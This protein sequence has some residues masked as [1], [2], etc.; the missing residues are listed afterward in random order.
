MKLM[1]YPT[2]A[3][4]LAFCAAT[5]LQAQWIQNSDV[6]PYEYTNPAN[7]QDGQINNLFTTQ[8]VSGLEITFNTDYALFGTLTM[9]WTGSPNVTFRSDSESPRTI[10]LNGGFVKTNNQGGTIT[11]GTVTHPLIL[12]LNGATRQLGGQSQLGTADGTCNIYAQIVDSSGGVN[13]VNLSGSRI[14][15]FLRNDNNSFV[16]PVRFVNLRGGGFTSISNIGE[17]PSAMGA[18][19]DETNG[20]IT[21]VDNSSTGRLEYNGTGGHSTDRP[22]VWN[23]TGNLYSFQN[24]GAGPITFT[25][26]WTLPN[27]F[28]NIIAV[29]NH[30][31]HAGYLKGVGTTNHLVFRSLP[32]SDANFN[33]NRIVLTGLAND[34]PSMELTNV[35]VAYNNIA[36]PGVPC[37]LGTGG[38]IIHRGNEGTSAAQN[39]S[40]QGATL[41]YFGPSA[42][43]TRTVQFAGTGRNW[44]LDNA[45]NTTLTFTTDFDGASTGSGT[46]ARYLHFGVHQQGIIEVEGVI[47]NVAPTLNTTVVLGNAVGITLFSGGRVRLLNPT[48]TFSGGIQVKYGR[49]A[50]AATL[51]DTGTESSIGT[52]T[53]APSGWTGITLGSTDSQRGGTLAYI[54]TTDAVCNRQVT[55]LGSA[56]GG[57]FGAILNNSPNHSSLHL[58]DLGSW[59]LH[60]GMS[61]CAVNL[62]GTALATNILDATLPNTTLGNLNLNVNGSIWKLTATHSYLG[63]TRVTNATLLVEGSIGPAED[64]TVLKDGVLGGNGTIYNDVTIE[65]DGTLSPGTSIGKLT[66]AGNLSSQGTMLM[67]VDKAASTNDQVVGVGT[68]VYGGKLQV[69]FEPGSLAAGD[70]FK[71]FDA[72][73]YLGAFN[74]I[75]PATPGSG[76][77]WDPSDLATTGTL[78]VATGT[79]ESPKLT[80]GFDGSNLTVSWP[81]EY[82]GYRLEGQTNALNV[83][84]STNWVPVP[85]TGNPAVIPVNPANGAVFYRLVNP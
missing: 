3:L 71:L 44:G 27:K 46:A 37:A 16:G 69:A 52:G 72:V 29:S 31:H 54:G 85:D 76:L 11:I 21:L 32:F 50:E 74:E 61:N 15:T 65:P 73:T 53:S 67:E 68:V 28:F 19:T 4:A 10:Y 70:S 66:I 2:F 57:A 59:S 49:F 26:P 39:R 17:G 41:Q 34:F 56:Q 38:T 84:L 5:G 36:D 58:S 12:D 43:F 79:T 9:A 83:G 51:A 7:W 24:R 18:P 81:A 77:Q 25:G 60:S 64:V 22:F 45:T 6:G 14:Y 80:I 33:T 13:G 23:M 20:T 40:G 63:W 82:S 55:I 42:S 47:P 48:N 62:G 78:R 30:I 1:R 35:V 75:E 8:P